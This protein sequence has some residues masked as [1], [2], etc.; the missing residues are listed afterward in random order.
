MRNKEKVE[1]KR[2]ACF[3]IIVL[4]QQVSKHKPGAKLVCHTCP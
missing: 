2:S 4:S 1:G 3:Y